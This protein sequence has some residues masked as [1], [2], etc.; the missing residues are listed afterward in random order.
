MSTMVSLQDLLKDI[1]SNHGETYENALAG[2]SPA[3]AW[4]GPELPLE[5]EYRVRVDK[6]EFKVS[7]ASGNP[8]IVLTFE[9]TEPAEYEGRKFQDYYSPKPTNEVGSRKLAELFGSLQATLEGWGEDVDG[10]VGQF[11]DKTATVTLRRWGQNND[12]TG[13]RYINMDKGQTLRTNIVAQKPRTDGRAA[14]ADL[15]PEINI[16]KDAAPVEGVVTPPVVTPP[17]VQQQT[18]TPP[19][20]INLPPGL[21]G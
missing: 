17:V 1:K 19:S 11:L 2:K 3:G 16:P 10:F 18:V 20:G 6:S 12:R 8:Q 14:A 4:D 13:V 7:Q 15:R 5:L 9:V 21:A